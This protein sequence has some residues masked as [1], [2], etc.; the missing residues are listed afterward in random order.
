MP[1]TDK[2]SHLRGHRVGADTLWWQLTPAELDWSD[3]QTLLYLDPFSRRHQGTGRLR[4]LAGPG[5]TLTSL[6]RARVL[7]SCA[8]L[9]PRHLFNAGHMLEILQTPPQLSCS[10]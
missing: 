5:C 4:S 2:N 1:G 8:A 3:P 9:C 7:E 10:F 6:T